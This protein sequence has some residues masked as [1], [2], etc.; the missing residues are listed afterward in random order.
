[1]CLLVA[2][3]QPV[4][5]YDADFDACDSLTADSC[6]LLVIRQDPYWKVGT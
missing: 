6:M 4:F 3:L 2:R 1:M 5:E